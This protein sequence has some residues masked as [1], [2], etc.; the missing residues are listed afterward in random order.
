MVINFKH[1]CF[2]EQYSSD[3]KLNTPSIHDPNIALLQPKRLTGTY[4]KEDYTDTYIKKRLGYTNIIKASDITKN[5]S[6]YIVVL[7]FWYF[8]D[9]IDLKPKHG[10]YIHSLS[11]PFNEEMEISYDRMKNWL[12]HFNIRFF[13]S[14]CSGHI[15]GDDLKKL[16][17]SI[18][19]K[20]L[21]PIHTEHPELFQK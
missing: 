6:R 16:I 4:I 12:H 13:Q 7:N 11:E 8:S 19:P 2:L 10:L 17:T 9:L 3:K 14:H 1:A 21:Y 15:N 20:T 5:P 18:H